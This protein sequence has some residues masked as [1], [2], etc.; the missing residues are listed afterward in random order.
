M[1]RFE[2][3]LESTN[4]ASC[5]GLFFF[6]HVDDSFNE[7]LLSIYLLVWLELILI[8]WLQRWSTTRSR[9]VHRHLN[10]FDAKRVNHLPSPILP[11][12]KRRRWQE[13]KHLKMVTMEEWYRSRQCVS[14]LLWMHH[15]FRNLKKLLMIQATMHKRRARL[16]TVPQ[17]RSLLLRNNDPLSYRKKIRPIHV[18]GSL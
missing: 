16:M 15:V 4:K 17:H 3:C 13:S 9:Q 18:Y 5:R 6:R 12:K 1:H 2:W 11:W 10:Q 14:K 8:H 7:Y